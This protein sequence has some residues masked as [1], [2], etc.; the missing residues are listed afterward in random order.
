MKALD[1]SHV[2]KYFVEGER[3][4]Q[5][6]TSLLL[7]RVLVPIANS[8]NPGQPGRGPFRRNEIRLLDPSGNYIFQATV[9]VQDGSKVEIMTKGVNELM[10]LKETLKGVLELEMAERLALDTRVR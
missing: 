8:Q 6:S 7:Y 3:L 10:S 4:T 5:N 1:Y 2:S 9:R